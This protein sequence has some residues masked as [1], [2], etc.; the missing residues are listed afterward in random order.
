M[1]VEEI[2]AAWRRNAVEGRAVDTVD[3][4]NLFVVC[5]AYEALL[6][7]NDALVKRLADKVCDA[8]ASLLAKVEGLE[9]DAAAMMA[10][11]ESRI[12]HEGAGAVHHAGSWYVAHEYHLT[13]Q[14]AMRDLLAAMQKDQA[15]GV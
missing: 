5:D 2:I 11:A 6:A 4:A 1:K 14:K 9:K 8:N 15:G 12:A 3:T 7:E 13:R 10:R